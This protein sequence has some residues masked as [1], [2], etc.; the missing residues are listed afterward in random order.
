[1][2]YGALP[3]LGPHDPRVV[4]DVGRSP[5][6]AVLRVQI[7]G[8]AL[9]TAVLVAPQTVLTAAHCLY[10]ARLGHFVPPAAIHVLNGYASGNFAGH[11]L[12]QS[13]RL[14]PGYNPHAPDATRGSDA[15]VLSLA[16]P[17][18]ATPLPLASPPPPG[19]IVVLAGYSQDRAQR[20]QI[21]PTCQI[22][23]ATPTLLAHSCTGTK[24]GSGG[25]LLHQAPD[26]NWNIVG[27]QSAANQHDAGGLAISA[28]TLRALVK[29]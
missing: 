13:Y 16:D 23:A 25:P 10:S 15:A 5:W 21:D 9:C 7:P 1:M 19:Q 4:A 22:R 20:L 26:G 28:T 2:S 18:A 12:V 11:T 6:N 17:I 8:V 27:L 3:G 24:G 14:A 29:E